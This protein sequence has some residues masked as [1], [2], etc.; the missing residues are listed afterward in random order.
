[1]TWRGVGQRTH[2]AIVSCRSRIA[3]TRRGPSPGSGSVLRSSLTV[4]MLS[5]EGRSTV[6][7]GSKMGCRV[8]GHAQMPS[9][10]IQGGA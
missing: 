9:S 8:R 1:M 5:L 4:W 2:M 10:L 6:G 7:A 3:H